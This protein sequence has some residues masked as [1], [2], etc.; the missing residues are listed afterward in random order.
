MVYDKRVLNKFLVLLVLSL[1]ALIIF[2]YSFISLID[3][4]VS[5]VN[6][7]DTWAVYLISISL[8]VCFF[9]FPPPNKRKVIIFREVFSAF[10]R[11]FIQRNDAN[12]SIVN[13]D[14]NNI[15]F[16][17]DQLEE[18]SLELDKYYFNNS[19]IT[20]NNYN[21]NKTTHPS[22][23]N[24]IDSTVPLVKPNPF[25]R[26][27]FKLFYSFFSF[28]FQPIQ[29]FFSAILL[30]FGGGCSRLIKFQFNLFFPNGDIP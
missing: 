16:L 15:S 10:K 5:L 24:A 26:F 19:K 7:L 8:C 4:L 2:L 9:P 11:K 28:L 13:D 3:Q 21:R 20:S 29:N 23:N 22:L 12:V 17:N 27:S 6:T 1:P 25:S 30:K 14:L 18:L